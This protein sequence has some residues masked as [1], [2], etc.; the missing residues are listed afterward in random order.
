MIRLSVCNHDPETTVL[1][2]LRK[3][4]YGMGLKPPDIVAIWGCSA[5]HDAIDRRN[6]TRKFT[7]EQLDE[8]ILRAL[9]EQLTYYAKAGVVKW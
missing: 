8:A 5:C 6:H 4:F 1:C 2:H 7:S 9:C 3:G